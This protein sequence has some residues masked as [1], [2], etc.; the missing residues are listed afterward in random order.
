MSD[1]FIGEL[2]LVSFPFAPKFWLECDGQI[3]AI[4]ANAALFSLL[5]TTYGGDG[6]N[7]FALPDLQGRVALHFGAGHS[8]GEKGG[9]ILHTL[10]GAESPSHS[11]YLNAVNAAASL[12][13]PGAALFANTSGNATVYGASNT[14]TTLQPAS[15]STVGGGQ[16]H[17]NEQ[18]YLAMNWIIC[19][20]GLFPSRN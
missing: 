6:I 3:L 18:P 2:K 9:E 10:T 1:S 4:R 20:A 15:V 14:P 8:Q 12:G 5:G 13:N 16:G 11:H 19:T 7:S 17:V